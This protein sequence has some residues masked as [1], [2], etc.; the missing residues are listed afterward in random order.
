MAFEI[1]HKYLVVNL[2]FMDMT[3]GSEVMSQGYL[4][5]DPERTVRIRIAGEKGY[6]TVKS[7]TK[8]DTRMEFEYNIPLEDAQQLLT[9]CQKPILKKTR[10]YVNF[11]GFKW[12]ID[13][14]TGHLA[15]LIIAEIELPTSDTTYPLPPFVGKEITGDARYYNSNL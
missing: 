1:E 5:R 4:S 3:S 8:G 2:S 9:L 11:K 13:V 15:P 7:I 12:E 14:Y 6:I 10:Y